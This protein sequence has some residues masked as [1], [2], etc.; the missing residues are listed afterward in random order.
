MNEVKEVCDTMLDEPEPPMLADE[1][2][3]S[4]VQGAARR[5]TARRLVGAGAGGV[6]LAGL[7]AAALIAPG[8]V[9]APAPGHRSG[10]LAG[11]P[12]PAGQLPDMVA[13]AQTALPDLPTGEQVQAHGDQ[14]YRILL[15]AVP[16]GYQAERRFGD[17]NLPVLWLVERSK[18]ASYGSGGVNA[19]T[20]SYVA[21]SSLLMKKDGR[22]GELA[23]YV[24]GD[25][26]P[27]PTGD[28]CAA[29]VNA[30]V[31]P[32]MGAGESCQVITVDSLPVRVTTRQNAEQ[33]EVI[34]ATWFVRN[35]F[36]T[37]SSRQGL[38]KYQ[39]DTRKPLDAPESGGRLP[40]Y[41]PP[42]KSPM[43]TPQQLASI[44]ANPDLL[45]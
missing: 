32:I 38:P 4:V 35:G 6:G 41:R 36:V 5:Q 39:P 22:E 33:R 31:D 30:R 11:A 20:A 40:E 28:L 27:T 1:E 2:A 34:D 12:T 16:D 45:P 13:A 19:K 9:S 29:K 8:L 26:K 43:F 21:I 15:D 24:W 18:K 7:L 10:Q 3:L 17:G 23:A 14:I 25:G 44:A 37:V 42:L